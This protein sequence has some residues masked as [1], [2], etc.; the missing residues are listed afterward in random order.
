M[1]TDREYS[2]KLDLM[3]RAMELDKEQKL[4]RYGEVRY[5]VGNGN[6][7][8]ARITDHIEG[9]PAGMYWDSETG[10]FEF[11]GLGL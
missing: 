6:T 5:A 1:K 9:A 2:R 10:N 11:D 4:M 8:I 7:C 3:W